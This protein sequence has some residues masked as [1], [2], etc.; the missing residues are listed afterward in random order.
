MRFAVPT[1]TNLMTGSGLGMRLV[2]SSGWVGLGYGAS[3]A[4]RLASNLV[5]TR[6]LYPEAFGLMALITVFLVGLTMLSDIGISP[7]IQ[8]S[9]R[10][11]EPEFYNTA[12]SVQAV[13]GVILWIASCVLGVVAAWFYGDNQLCYMLPVAGLSLLIAGFNPTRI[14]TAARHLDVGRV[15]MLDLLA[16]ILGLAVTLVLTWVMQSIWALVI[17]GVVTTLI[18]L[19]IMH[20]LLPGPRNQFSWE[21]QA[22]SELIRF[23]GWIFLSTVCGF[24]IAQGDKAIMG[25]YLSLEM[26]GI[27]NIGYFL[28]GFPQAL[29]AAV[30]ARV[31]IP[32]HR[33]CPPGASDSNFQKIRRMRFM[34][35]AAVFAMQFTMAFLGILIVSILYD[36][37]FFAA[38]SVVVAVACMNI[39]YLLGMTYD[40][41]ALAQGDSRRLFH[42]LF[43]KAIVQTTLFIVGMELAGLPGAL[44]GTLLSQALVHPFVIRLARRYGAWDPWHDLFYGTI[45]LALTASVLLYHWGDLAPL[46]RFSIAH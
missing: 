30:L 46:W 12:W 35:T 29:A 11:D 36:H 18:R 44:V 45:G 38:G 21:P 25:K 34:V 32:L 13:R 4:I 28:A 14:E 1:L 39:P 22:A 15:T 3:Q 23:G 37:R 42:L 43:V 20:F 16:Q 40:Y 5:L 8:H 19:L 10:G 7:S 26:L 24:L 31:M 41:P 6:L 2:R 17:G 9:R 33:E 27:Y